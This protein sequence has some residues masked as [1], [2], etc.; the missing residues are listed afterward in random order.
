MTP[1]TKKKASDDGGGAQQEQRQLLPP[2]PSASLATAQTLCSSVTFFPVLALQRMLQCFGY[3][4]VVTLQ[5]GRTYVSTCND[6][7]HRSTRALLTWV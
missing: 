7:P 4:H 2:P 3:S 6:Q 5:S 1:G